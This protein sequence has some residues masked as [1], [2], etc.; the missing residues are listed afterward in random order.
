VIYKVIVEITAQREALEYATYLM[1][2]C[3]SFTTADTWLTELED[4]VENLAHMPRQ[5][6][7][8]PEQE[9]FSIELRQFHH[10]SHRVVFHINDDAQSV[11]VL[12]VYHGRRA[13]L[14]QVALPPS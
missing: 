3:Q 11:H 9:H 14:S 7:V 5:F 2:E 13:P 10:H 12:R 4:A 6:R 1:E 8:I